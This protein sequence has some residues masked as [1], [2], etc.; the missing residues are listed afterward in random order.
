MHKRGSA[1]LRRQAGVQPQ[2]SALRH[3]RARKVRHLLLR[4]LRRYH[5]LTYTN[6]GHLAPIL[7]RGSNITTLDSTGTVVGAFPVARYGEKTIELQ[8]GDTLVAY[9][10]GIIEPENA[11][12]EMFGEERLQEL[13]LK[14]AREDSTEIIARTMEAVNQWT[15]SSELQD[16]MTMVVARRL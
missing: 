11:Y 8:Q 6:A 10:D 7:L 1:L 5:S 9:T 3:H 4:P 15:G 14:H 12:G 16:D 2:P 13:L